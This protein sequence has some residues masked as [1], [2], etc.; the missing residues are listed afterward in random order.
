MTRNNSKREH[1][2]RFLRSENSRILL[3]KP[4]KHMWNVIKITSHCSC[5]PDSGGLKSAEGSR[6]EED[7]EEFILHIQ[8]HT[9]G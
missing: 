7:F 5:E 4:C 1:K 3:T 9:E 2:G 8:V 6:H